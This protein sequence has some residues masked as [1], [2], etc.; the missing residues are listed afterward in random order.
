MDHTPTLEHFS[1]NGLV[2]IGST[3]RDHLLPV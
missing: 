1:S 3:N 2:I